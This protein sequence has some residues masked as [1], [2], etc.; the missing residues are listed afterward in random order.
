MADCAFALSQKTLWIA[1]ETGLVGR[2]T[3]RAL[4]KHNVKIL[5]APHSVLDLTKQKDTFEWFFANKPDAVIMA[6]GRV[7]GIGANAAYPADFIRD[8]LM[9]AQNV[10]EGAYRAGV[11]HLL[12]LGSS[13]IYPKHAVQPMAEEVFLTGP[14]EETNEAYAI[15]KIAGMKLCQFYQRQFGQRYISAM[16]ANLYGMF[17]RF[18]PDGG[19]V[20]PA[21]IMKF[22]AAKLSGASHVKVWGSGNPLREFLHVDDLARALLILLEVYDG[23][24]HINI[25]SGAEISIRDLA[26]LIKDVTGFAG[27]IAFDA[28]KPD[29]MPRKIMDSSRMRNFG[30]RPDISL[31]DGLAQTYQWYCESL[32]QGLKKTA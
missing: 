1:G 24:R 30:W 7:G 27:S 2:A 6:A 13:C 20:I 11:Q 5:S 22:H 10:I 18:D 15:A 3:L 21:M 19:H 12:Y 23:E 25:G 17:D 16:P 31:K 32:E 29:G 26:I 8:N 4:E 9:M 14:L 28:D